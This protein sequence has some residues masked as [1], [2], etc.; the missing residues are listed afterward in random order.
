M[1]YNYGGQQASRRG[2]FS[3]TARL[4]RLGARGLSPLWRGARRRCREFSA[5]ISSRTRRR[6]QR[7]ARGEKAR[8][9][10][11][12]RP[13]TLFPRRSA[14]LPPSSQPTGDAAAQWS[15][16][17]AAYAAYQAQQAAAQAGGAP[18]DPRAGYGAA[19]AA[20]AGGYPPAA[21]GYPPAAGGWGAQPPQPPP[22]DS[23]TIYV[24]GLAQSV[25]PEWITYLF[26]NCGE[27]KQIRIAGQARE[28]G[29]RRAPR[30]APPPDP[31]PAPSRRSRPHCPI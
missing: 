6:R 7:R 13:P 15:A 1:S 4:C 11:R 12:R 23:P 19:P 25:T 21:G 14:L 5:L 30:A 28:D 24:G 2:A 17:Q 16:Q 29:G 26:G 9:E 22:A 27:I 20:A 8:R 31:A 10:R 18:Q 3:R